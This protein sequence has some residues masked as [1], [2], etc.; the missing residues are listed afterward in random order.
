MKFAD[1]IPI[2]FL[3]IFNLYRGKNSIKTLE[4]KILFLLLSDLVSL[5]NHYETK[6][7]QGTI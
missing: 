4:R 7:G 2:I 6:G 3:G 1:K 5:N